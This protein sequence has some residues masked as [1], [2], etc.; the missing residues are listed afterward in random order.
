MYKTFGSVT[1]APTVENYE[2][3]LIDIRD[4]LLA[5]G[6]CVALVSPPVLGEDRNSEA[7]QRCAKYAEVVRRT[8]ARGGE[9]CTYLPLFERTA[10]AL[11]AGSGSPYDGLRFFGWLCLLCVDIHVRRRCL[12]EV[13]RERNLGVTVDLVH[14]GPAAA[15]QLVE[16]VTD[17]VTNASPQLPSPAFLRSVTA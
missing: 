8:A 17:F 4:R 12:K 14:L 1:Q 13:Q 15:E 10:A 11:P 2:A 16:M 7:N 9:R 5:T 6:A 3:D